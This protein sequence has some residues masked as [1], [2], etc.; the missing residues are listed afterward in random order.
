MRWVT[1]IQSFVLAVDSAVAC[2]PALAPP[3]S[4]SLE[5]PGK[6]PLRQLLTDERAFVS[7]GF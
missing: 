7:P 6:Q 1:G 2:K 4:C 5:T 3:L